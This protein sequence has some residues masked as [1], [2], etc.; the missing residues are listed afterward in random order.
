[1][2]RQAAVVKCM[3]IGWLLAGAANGIQFWKRLSLKARLSGDHFGLQES[4]SLPPIWGDLRLLVWRSCL[5]LICIKKRTGNRV[6][7]RTSAV[8]EHRNNTTRSS[9]SLYVEVMQFYP[10]LRFRLNT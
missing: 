10:R 1:M 8:V 6:S 7:S 2:L 9:F 3:G 5:A 4:S